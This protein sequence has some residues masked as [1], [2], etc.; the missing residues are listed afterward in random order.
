MKRLAQLISLLALGLTVACPMLFFYEQLSLA[1]TQ[2]WML[3]GAII[4]FLATPFW[5]EHKA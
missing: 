1:R 2:V 5:M 4:W 3:I